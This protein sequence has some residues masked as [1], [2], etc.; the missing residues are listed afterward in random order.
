MQH[1]QPAA[2]DY[3]P[4]PELRG[5]INSLEELSEE[6]K[7]VAEYMAFHYDNRFPAPD[8]MGDIKLRLDW[9]HLDDFN[10]IELH[11]KN[12]IMIRVKGFHHDYHGRLENNKL[13]KL[14]DKKQYDNGV[15]DALI[16]YNG[17]LSDQRKSFFPKHWTP[18]VRTEKILESLQNATLDRRQ[19]TK[20]VF[21]GKTS[22]G[23]EIRT[24]IK[25][26]GEILTSYPI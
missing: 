22:E 20:Y 1:L 11:K 17:L 3:L 14:I 19:G 21:I 18:E 16:E 26:S 10:Y 24:I 8:V 25:T 6:S 15:Y 13:I 4:K 5:E 12:K 7:R 23:I 2:E 9:Q